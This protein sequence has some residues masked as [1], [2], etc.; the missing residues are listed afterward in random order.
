MMCKKDVATVE[1]GD[2]E[3]NIGQPCKLF[4]LNASKTGLLVR[5]KNFLTNQ[6]DYEDCH[7]SI[8]KQTRQLTENAEIESHETMIDNKINQVSFIFKYE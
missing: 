1:W 2:T 4:K 7:L 6:Y 3:G 5:P 8:S